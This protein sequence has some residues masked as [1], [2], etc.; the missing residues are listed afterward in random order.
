MTGSVFLA[1]AITM[2][3]GQQQPQQQTVTPTPATKATTTAAKPVF[4]KNYEE[5]YLRYL[6]SV[7]QQQPATASNLFMTD[8]MLDPVARRVGDVITIRV[9]E[10]ISAAGSA[11]SN[12]GKASAGNVSVPM[13]VLPVNSS[14]LPSGDLFKWGPITAETK[15][16]GS[17]GTNRSTS[18]TAFMTARVAEV[19]PNGQLVIEGVR[20]IDINGDKSLVV[21]TGIARIVDIAPG[22]VIASSQIGEFRIQALSRGLIKDSLSPGWLIKA[23]NKIF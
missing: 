17:G 23:L 1:F 7:R 18:L 4:T 2:L 11:D 16:N 13:P 19:L 6:T 22:N 21:V 8:L 15:F 14:L 10:S 12:V 3:G 5:A 9:I 20:E